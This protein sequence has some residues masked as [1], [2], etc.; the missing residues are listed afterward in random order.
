MF[1][2]VK[3]FHEINARGVWKR[4]GGGWNRRTY[5]RHRKFYVD[6]VIEGENLL[7]GLSGSLDVW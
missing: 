7:T 3:D 1:P 5:C 2:F 6:F 4:G